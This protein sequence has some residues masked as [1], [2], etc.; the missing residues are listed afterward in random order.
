[1]Y[2][3]DADC[4]PD[5]E[6]GVAKCR[7]FKQAAGASIAPS[8]DGGAPCVLSALGIQNGTE[9]Y[10]NGE[11]L[12]TAMGNGALISTFAKDFKNTSY[13]PPIAYEYCEPGSPFAYCFGA[14]CVDDPEDSTRAICSCPYV[15]SSSELPQT[16]TVPK[17]QCSLG[18]EKICTAVWN[19]DPIDSRGE[20]LY[21]ILKVADDCSTVRQASPAESTAPSTGIAASPAKSTATI[22]VLGAVFA[23]TLLAGL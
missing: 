1:M 20:G 17:T 11:D 22:P 2:C 9:P 15:Y 6:N 13:I 14:P 7:C 10:P 16:L 23:A 12:C 3:I 4:D 18:K 8:G 5:V 21:D 19:D